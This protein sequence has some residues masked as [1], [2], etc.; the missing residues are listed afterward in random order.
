MS[1]FLLILK[2][3]GIVLLSVIG[4]IL[5]LIALVLFVPIRYRV[6]ADYDET[7]T[8]SVKISYLLH[9]VTFL[10]SYD[11]QKSDKV[12]KIFGIK[13]SKKD[14]VKKEKPE[15]TKKKAKDEKPDEP[16]YVLEG[17]DD[18]EEYKIEDPQ[19]EV[20]TESDFPGE[21]E[22]HK[23]FFGKLKEYLQ[24]VY[25]FI[26]NF[27]EKIKAFFAK[28]KGIKDNI[29]Y[30]LDLFTDEHNKETFKYAFGIIFKILNAVKPR[31]LD[32]AFRFGFEDP[33]TTG[34]LLS[35]LAIIYPFTG[36]AIKITPEFDEEIMQGNLFAKGRIFII[37]LLIQ[38][39]K[40]YFNKDIRKVIRDIKREN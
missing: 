24:Y 19:T 35:V 8:A 22:E 13:L 39:W 18:E 9:I 21:E 40:L 14:K 33:E 36:G 32:G 30:Y 7:F 31:K 34:K 11:G 25:N 6:L 2:I 29:E 16:E 38:G 37:T 27:S 28:V 12:L 4:L 23:G 20:Y 10:F 5:L 26:S 15:K 1:I 17:F 3:I